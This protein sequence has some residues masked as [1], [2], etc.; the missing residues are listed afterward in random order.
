MK[1]CKGPALSPVAEPTEAKGE[2]AGEEQRLKVLM[3]LAL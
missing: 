2:D 3:E 1:I